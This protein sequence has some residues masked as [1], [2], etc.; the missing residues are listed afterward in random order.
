LVEHA[1]MAEIQPQA[2]CVVQ[3]FKPYLKKGRS[4]TVFGFG[5]ACELV[6]GR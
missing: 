2:D 1:R 6:E 3:T 5:S 4:L